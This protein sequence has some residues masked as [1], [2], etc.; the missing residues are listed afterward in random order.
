MNPDQ[1]NR[2]IIASAHSAVVEITSAHATDESGNEGDRQRGADNLPSWQTV[3]IGCTRHQSSTS[4]HRNSVPGKF[5]ALAYHST[6][7]LSFGKMGGMRKAQRLC[8]SGSDLGFP[9]PDKS[10]SR[11]VAMPTNSC[12]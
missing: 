9:S 1:T 2:H 12:F 8:G 6:S 4:R 5:N 10:A 7:A 11:K 3:D